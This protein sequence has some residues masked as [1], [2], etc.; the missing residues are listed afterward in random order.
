MGVRISP[1][2]PKSLRGHHFYKGASKIVD[3]ELLRSQAFN[4][5]NRFPEYSSNVL[6]LIEECEKDRDRIFAYQGMR[7]EDDKIIRGL[8][9]YLEVADKLGKAIANFIDHDG[10]EL[11]VYQALQEW[12]KSDKEIKVV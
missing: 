12:K 11:D 3:L 6:A 7:E 9:E 8:V 4:F 1:S 2:A 5:L 10:D